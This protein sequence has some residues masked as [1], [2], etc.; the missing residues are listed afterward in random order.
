MVN[1]LRVEDLLLKGSKV[2][3]RVD[4]NV[5]LNKDGTISD[6]TRIREALPTIQ[7]ILNQGGSVILIS[8]LG[9]PQSKRDIQYS[10]GICAKRLSQL[11][12]APVFFTTDCVGKETEKAIQELKGGQVLV[13]ENL[14]FYPAEE[15]PSLDSTFG[16]QLATL[17]DFYVN[18]AFGTAHRAHTSTVIVPSLLPNKSAM[19]LLIQ[20]ELAF[21]NPLFKNP[22]HPFFA[23]IGGAKISTKLG[24]LK[25][26]LSKVDALF[27]GGGMAFTFLKAQGIEIGDSIYDETSLQQALSLL[28]ASSKTKIYFPVDLVIADAFRKDAT[29]KTIRVEEGIPKGWQGVDIG[30]QTVQIWTKA[31]QDA[32][33]VFWNG[34][35]GVFEFPLFARG[36]Q[37]IAKAIASLKATTVVG[38]GD[39]VAAINSLGLASAFSH[40]STGGGAAFEYLEFGHLPG[41]DALSDKK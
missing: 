5:P 31:L 11:I 2:L 10:L 16:K 21:L 12:A 40:I 3:V 33:T 32:A 17:A 15:K 7:Y 36:T 6:D 28:E 25:S 24:V 38:G 14:R 8:H 13:L 26:I 4:F 23:V 1:K 39:S 30:P 22:S 34:P 20:K 41:I 9:K 37:E 27:I 35:L 29:Y 18:D 19:G